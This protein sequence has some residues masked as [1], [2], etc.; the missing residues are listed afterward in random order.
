MSKVTCSFCGNEVHKNSLVRHQRTTKYCLE[1]Q[2]IKKVTYKCECNKN[3]QSMEDLENHQDICHVLLKKEISV[4]KA[5]LEAVEETAKLKGLLEG[6]EEFLDY[7]KKNVK[8][9]NNNTT[10]NNTMNIGVMN[11]NQDYIKEQ[12]QFYTLDHYLQGAKGMAEFIVN[13]IITDKDGNRLYGCSDKNRK[14]FFY[15]NEQGEKV[16]DIKGDK[17]ITVVNQEVKPIATEYRKEQYTKI[18]ND[19]IGEDQS[20][21]D[22]IARLTK[23]NKKKY[24]E[25]F[26]NKVLDNMVVALY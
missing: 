9:I 13:N 5:K 6:K 7:T 16:D 21:D 14:H 18:V 22:K 10:T 20:S 4:L 11:W 24:D 19:N 25:S 2:G 3:F 8:T 12:T 26:S 17:L 23:E 15:I 1:K